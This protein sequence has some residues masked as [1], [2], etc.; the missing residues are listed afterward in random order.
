MDDN[1]QLRA[2]S[3][4]RNVRPSRMID[5]VYQSGDLQKDNRLQ[6]RSCTNIDNLVGT[7]EI[8]KKSPHHHLH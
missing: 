6:A 7:L 4:A 5:G 2:K 1:A 8:P 3:R